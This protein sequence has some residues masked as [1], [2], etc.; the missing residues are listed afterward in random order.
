MY[1]HKHESC[2]SY[3]EDS[4][5][6]CNGV[7]LTGLC[8]YP[9]V[10]K[11]THH[12]HTMNEPSDVDSLISALDSRSNTRSG[13]VVQSKDG[14]IKEGTYITENTANAAEFD[15]YS[16]RFDALFNDR[17]SYQAI[18]REQPRHRLILWM[19]ANG[20]SPKE[21]ASALRITV[22]TVYNVR[23]QPWFREMFATLTT[24]L[25]RDA[26]EMFLKAE[27]MPSLETLREIRDDTTARP[28]DRRACADSL[29]DRFLGKP[30]AKN[31]NDAKA[32]ND[33]TSDKQKLLQ[34]AVN[35]DREL[36]VRGV[37]L[38]TNDNN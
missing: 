17:P 37:N 19:T 4:A 1:D 5:R 16:Q 3:F 38:E 6:G 12:A 9:Y 11:T 15:E 33:I 14:T 34:E 25:G 2:D 31:D 8:T 7:S 32:P 26:T 35:L 28:A 23:R 10:C 27:V 13:R 24:E 18:L 21:V 22:Q 36:K 29:L 30:V 20:H